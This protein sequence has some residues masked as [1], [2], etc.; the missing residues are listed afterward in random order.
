[1]F[2]RSVQ[3]HPKQAAW[4]MVLVVV[5]WLAAC[6]GDEG[7]GTDTTPDVEADGSGGDA[8]GSGDVAEDTS[9]DD[10]AVDTGV[11]ELQ[12]CVPGTRI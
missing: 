6:G 12:Q 8:D 9:V 11:A 10:T 3:V 1:M 2:A 4:W 7:A 5:P